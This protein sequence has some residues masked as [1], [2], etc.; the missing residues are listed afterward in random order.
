MVK[1][2]RWYRF[3]ATDEF[4]VFIN[5]VRVLTLIGVVVLIAVMATNIEQ[6][7]LLA[8]DACR[9]CMNKTGATCIMPIG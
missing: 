2:T 7:K 4:I 5:L 1:D 6:V 9:V 3:M 8:T